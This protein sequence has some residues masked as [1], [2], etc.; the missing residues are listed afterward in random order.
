MEI[1][2]NIMYTT[3]QK[4]KSLSNRETIHYLTL[5]CYPRLIIKSYLYVQTTVL[6]IPLYDIIQNLFMICQSATVV[7]HKKNINTKVRS[8]VNLSTVVR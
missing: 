7:I 1:S 3:S 5:N 8:M 4:L 6:L 2:T